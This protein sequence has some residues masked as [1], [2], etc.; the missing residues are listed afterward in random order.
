MKLHIPE[1]SLAQFCRKWKVRE[2]ALFGSALTDDF[3]PE[4]DVDLLVDFA[5]DADLSLYDWLEMRGE[6]EALFGRQ[7][8]LVSQEDLR[9]PFRRHSVLTSKEI[10]Y[11]T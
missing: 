7:V 6:L 11:A 2:L 1:K 8:D 3:G 9:N 10:L 5:D 4:S